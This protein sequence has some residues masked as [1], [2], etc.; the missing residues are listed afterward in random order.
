MTCVMGNSRELLATW[1]ARAL[2]IATHA[3]NNTPGPQ[4]HGLL[5]DSAGLSRAARQ[6]RALEQKAAAASL[7]SSPPPSD[8]LADLGQPQCHGELPT[9]VGTGTAPEGK[10]NE[11]QSGSEEEDLV[12]AKMGPMPTAAARLGAHEQRA[13]A[14]Q[15][16]ATEHLTVAAA[17]K[18]RPNRGPTWCPAKADG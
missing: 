17:K 5:R 4:G 13:A 9:P 16:A 12:L 6:K 18:C 3:A 2:A 7:P 11:D 1:A 15:R 10:E 14:A 8:N